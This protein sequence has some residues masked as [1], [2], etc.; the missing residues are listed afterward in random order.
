MLGE[1][2]MRGRLLI[3]IVA[4]LLGLLGAVGCGDDEDGTTNQS[5]SDTA[6]QTTPGDDDPQGGATGGE[7]TEPE[8]E[9]DP[10]KAEFVAEANALCAKRV[11]E[12]QLKGQKVFKKVFKYPGPVAAKKLADAVIVPIFSRELR[13]LKALPQPPDDAKELD[14]FYKE[15]ERIIDYFSGKPQP[16]AYP[17]NKSEK[18]ASDY[19]I[20]KCGRPQ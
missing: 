1:L 2:N 8:A 20:D 9:A 6:A 4:A 18:L 17:Y 7:T 16:G 15:M 14:V 19:G 13:E 3:A 10:A 5:G 11:A 12:V